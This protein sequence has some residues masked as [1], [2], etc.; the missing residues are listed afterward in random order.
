MHTDP[1]SPLFAFSISLFFAFCVFPLL[2]GQGNPPPQK[3][4]MCFAEVSSP[5]PKVTYGLGVYGSGKFATEVS[6]AEP[7]G[8][9]AEISRH[10]G[11]RMFAEASEAFQQLGAFLSD[12]VL[13]ELLGV[14]CPGQGG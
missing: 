3:N 2:F 1:D 11:W 6:E 13:P 12:K 14:G 10:L 9:F 4:K 8:R 5:S 7:G